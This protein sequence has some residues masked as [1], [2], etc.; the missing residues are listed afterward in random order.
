LRAPQW[1]TSHAKSRHD[2]NSGISKR[3]ESVVGHCTTL[4]QRF[5]VNSRTVNCVPFKII[6]SIKVF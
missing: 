4:L 1:F 5:V 3:R 2:F 6:F